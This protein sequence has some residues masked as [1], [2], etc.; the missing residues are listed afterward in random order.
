VTAIYGY[1]YRVGG[2]QRHHV[3]T[4][5]MW[6]LAIT[7]T[8][9]A[10]RPPATRPPAA[11]P[12]RLKL[13]RVALLAGFTSLGF[14]IYGSTLGLGFLSD[15]F[16][17]AARAAR[18][19]FLGPTAEFFRPLSLLVYKL[20]GSR[21]FALHAFNIVLHGVNSALVVP[22]SLA[23][24]LS[25]TVAAVAGGLF[26][27][28]PGH[29]EAVAWCAG[30]QDVLMTALTLAAVVMFRTRP[31]WASMPFAAALLAK[32]TAV[33]GPALAWLSQPRRWRAV[34]AGAGLVIVYAMLR[35][36]FGPVSRGYIVAPTSYLIKE[37]LV[38]PFAT[39]TVPLHAEVVLRWPLVG[40]VLASAVVLLVMR[41]AWIW[42]GD[43]RV[44]ATLV[45]LAVW[46]LAGAAPVYA[47]LNI[48]ATLQGARYL[49]LPA[50]GWAMLIAAL[51][52]PDRSRWNLAASVALCAAGV[53]GTM[54][55][56]RPW[57]AASALRDE[58]LGRA[59]TARAAGCVSV[60]VSDVPDSI[61][62]A[63]VFRNGLAEALDPI[64]LDE[65]APPRCRV[66]G[67]IAA[68]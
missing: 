48:T 4:A 22:L 55:N 15:D 56:L 50:C 68:R 16:V 3:E 21:P 14:G 31:A 63:Y 51:L 36:A 18:N 34:A 66:S 26:L 47:L 58:I 37:L 11:A 10:L 39:L 65:A 57:S 60:W 20:G 12:S 13:G 59:A 28:Y 29:V 42:Q 45:A 6:F 62:G 27:T 49:Y 7:V 2:A 17:L 53:A 52:A 67:G 46:V 19:E 9:A 33:A 43:R 61:Q 64:R 8:F 41:A 54:I 30:V 23:F 1:Y 35:I 38:R 5:W 24:G 40:V 25:P 32:E 44:I